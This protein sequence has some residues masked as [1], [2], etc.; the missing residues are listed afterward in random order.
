MAKTIAPNKTFQRTVGSRRPLKVNVVQKEM[1]RLPP[2]LR[3]W[4]FP[5]NWDLDRLWSLDVPTEMR[6]MSALDWH[7]HVPIWSIAKGM[8][9]D[10]RPVEVL[11]NPG[12]HPRHDRRIDE[13]DISYPI[14]MMFTVDRFA[15]IDGIHRLAKYQK[16][17]IRDVKVRIIPREM[18]PHFIRD[19]DAQPAA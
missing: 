12:L 17:G 7:F 14:D 16:L 6:D 8:H 3:D 5:F 13:T 2:E 4:Y 18:I 15:I 9:F 19:E 10:L 11:Q 1:K